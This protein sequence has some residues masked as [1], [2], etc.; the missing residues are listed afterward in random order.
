MPALKEGLKE[1][2]VAELIQAL[3][4]A[5]YVRKYPEL[6][7]FYNDVHAECITRRKSM[8]QEDVENIRSMITAHG[9]VTESIFFPFNYR[10]A[11]I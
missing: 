11:N 6:K 1:F 9:V 3:E 7:Q 5:N 10:P 2:E 4:V 8:S